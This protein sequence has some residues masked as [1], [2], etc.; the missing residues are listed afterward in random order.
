MNFIYDRITY[1]FDPLH[2]LWEHEKMHRKISICL[3]LF[4][5]ASLVVIELNRQ[6][7]L[8]G[9][10]AAII[11]QN[12]FFAVQAAFTVV[13]I[14]EVI[15]LVFTIP[16]S[17]SRS[18]G[19][20]FEILSLILMRNAFKELSGFAEPI[21]FKGNEEAIKYILSDGFGA[22]LIFA[23]LGCYYIV[24]SRASDE[25]MRPTDL[26]SFVAAKK[27]IALILLSIFLFMGIQSGIDT[28]TGKPHAD[29]LHGF[30]TLLILTDILIV[31]ISQCFQP[32]FYTIFRNSGFALSTLIIRIALAAPPFYNVLLGVAAAIFA[33]LLT[34]VSRWLF[35]ERAKKKKV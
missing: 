10:L 17:F 30:Y 14:L 24:Q 6:N 1:I 28:F 4:F 9:S 19:K 31:L 3:V 2:H 12:H 7:L 15:S 26:Y 11:P 22:L 8:P 25:R 27:G 29:F 34:I 33:I 18:V 32:S 35:L 16:C 13:L 23:L 20:Q 5:L 21:T